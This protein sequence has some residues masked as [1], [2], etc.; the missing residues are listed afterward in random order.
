MK[1]YT[2]LKFNYEVRRHDTYGLVVID[3][4]IG[5]NNTKRIAKYVMYSVTDKMPF[6][7]EKSSISDFKLVECKITH[8]TVLKKFFSEMD[9]LIFYSVAL[10]KNESE[11]NEARLLSRLS[12]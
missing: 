3:K 10:L 1:K 9:S 6:M 2:N 12:F 4:S 5:V 7:A 11:E 8:N